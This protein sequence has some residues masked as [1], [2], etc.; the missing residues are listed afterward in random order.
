MARGDDLILKISAD[1]SAVA[2]GLAPMNDALDTL[3][4][5][6]HEASDQLSKLDKMNVS[7]TVD[8]DIR[9]EAIA[10]ARQDIERLRD[11]VAHG[12][13]MG[14]DTRAAQR[15]ISSLQSAIKKLTSEPETVEIDVDVD[16]EAMADALGRTA[17]QSPLVPVYANVTAAP[18]SAPQDIVKLL[19]QQVTGTVR[20]RESVAAM[21]EAGVEE[22]VEL[23]GKVVGPMVRDITDRA[24]ATSVVTMN[25]IEALAARL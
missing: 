24:T 19:V 9:D 7:P 11:D 17:V 20:W 14:L 12:V 6:A 25:D 3:D 1:T 13:E 2:S 18:A 23:G 22:F 21:A 16:K 8:V 10:K 5:N 4:A 15:E